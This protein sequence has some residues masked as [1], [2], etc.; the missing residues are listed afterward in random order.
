[1]HRLVEWIFSETQK[2]PSY[3]Q[4]LYFREGPRSNTVLNTAI[5]LVPRRHGL[6]MFSKRKKTQSVVV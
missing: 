5:T 1:M 4:V 3:A 2:L 6:V